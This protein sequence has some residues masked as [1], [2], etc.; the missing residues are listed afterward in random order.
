MDFVERLQHSPAAETH[1][2]ASEDDIRQMLCTVRVKLPDDYKR[3]L[4]G[5]GWVRLGP[6]II[7][8]LGPDVSESESVDRNVV[9]EHVRAD[10]PMAS[11]LIPIMNDGAGNHFCLDTKQMKGG[12]CPVVFWDHEHPK[13]EMQRPRKIAGSFAQWILSLLEEEER[14]HG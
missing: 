11:N 1:R 7:Y 3:Y 6:N 4:L 8:G 9:F 10:P 14:L 2:G 12:T 13:G 5:C